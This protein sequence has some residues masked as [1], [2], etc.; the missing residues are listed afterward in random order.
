MS[1]SRPTG[2]FW[3]ENNTQKEGAEAGKKCH[4]NLGIRHT[5]AKISDVYV[6]I[7]SRDLSS[8]PGFNHGIGVTNR[9]EDDRHSRLVASLERFRL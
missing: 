9:P 4:Q 3:K 6:T 1:L 2:N 5:V 7:I 8:G